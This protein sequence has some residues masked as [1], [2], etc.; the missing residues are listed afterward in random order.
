MKLFNRNF[1]LHFVGYLVLSI[2]FYLLIPTLPVFA[3]D[4]LNARN[5]QVGFIIGIYALSALISRPVTGYCFDRFDKK[6]VYVLSLIGSSSVILGYHFVDSMSSLFIVRFLHGIAWSFI[7]TGSSAIV[8]DFIPI[9]QR[10]QG[11]SYFGLSFVIG[12]AVGPSMG[13]FL[14]VH[15]DFSILFN[16]IVCMSLIAVLFGSLIKTAKR[17]SKKVKIRRIKLFDPKALRLAIVVLLMGLPYAMVLTF[18]TLYAYEIGVDKNGLFFIV[19]AIGI[20][21][22]RLT[23]G[24]VMDIKGPR[25]IMIF[26]YMIGLCGLGLLLISNSNLAF[27]TAGLLLGFGN[28]S[29]LPLLLTMINNL[30]T[31]SKRGVANATFYTAADLGIGFGSIV[32]GYIASITSLK[33]MLGFTIAAEVISLIIFLV[34]AFQHYNK[35]KLVSS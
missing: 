10:G 21:L 13:Q 5:D 27:L 35:Y 19:F 1:T 14:I 34:I 12:M 33:S 20:I 8:V 7:T 31:N 4:T 28:G 2:G 23:T 3:V 16:V 32:L 24:K 11:I 15:Y 25:V 30:A 22:S 6:K 9:E 18:I 29:I 17:K 26:C